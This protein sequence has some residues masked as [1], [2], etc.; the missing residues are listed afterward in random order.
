MGQP[1][2]FSPAIGAAVTARYRFLWMRCPTCRT[3]TSIDLRTLDRHPDAT[4]TSL[5]PALSCRSCRPH[6]PFAEL[7]RFSKRS[8]ADELNVSRN[9]E[10]FGP[11]RLRKLARSFWFRRCG[12]IATNPNFR[13]FVR[14]RAD[15]RCAAGVH[16]KLCRKDW[17]VPTRRRAGNERG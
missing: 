10:R 11:R 9:R 3:T 1:K 14:P 8:I 5:I 7:V 2:L 6:A 4:V 12:F 15:V 13:T 16:L 17:P